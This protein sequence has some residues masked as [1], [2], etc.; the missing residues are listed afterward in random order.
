MLDNGKGVMYT[1]YMEATHMTRNPQGQFEPTDKPVATITQT[2]A[3][4]G[5]LTSNYYV[6][7]MDG[8]EIGADS[9]DR[10]ARYARGQG[11]KVS[12]V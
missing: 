8:R 9:R 6:L 3:K 5:C 4:N 12:N 11:Y 2:V 7:N 10:L 1:V